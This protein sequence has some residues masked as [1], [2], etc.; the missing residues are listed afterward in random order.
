MADRASIAVELTALLADMPS[1]GATAVVRAAWLRRKAVLLRRIAE[2]TADPAERTEAT[3]LAV[4]ADQ[5][6]D[7]TEC[8]G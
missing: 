7:R 3:V 6:A 4:L 2:E 8:G 5:S 1:V